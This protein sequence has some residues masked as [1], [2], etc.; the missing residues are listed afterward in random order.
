MEKCY[1]IVVCCIKYIVHDAA[2]AVVGQT[3][4][5]VITRLK[6]HKRSGPV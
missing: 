3:S 5:H 4:R 6:E 2:H 1:N